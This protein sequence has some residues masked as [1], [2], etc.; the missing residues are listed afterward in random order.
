MKYCLDCRRL[1]PGRAQVCGGCRKSFGGSLCPNK[2]LSPGW[3]NC[4]VVCGSKKLLPVARSLDLRTPMVLASWFV[5]LLGLK[6]LLSN[7][8]LILGLVFNLGDSVFSFVTGL[9]IGV[10]LGGL[11]QHGV[12]LGIIWVAFRKIL[13]ANSLPVRAI[14]RLIIAALRRTP[15]LLV[16]CARAFVRSISPRSHRERMPERGGP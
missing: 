8:G 9:S 10:L 3:A 13:G 2:H 1:H 7:L 5:G 4:C 15:A 14:E 6:L 11:I 16:W 12:V